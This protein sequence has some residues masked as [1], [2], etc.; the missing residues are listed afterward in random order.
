[1]TDIITKDE[2]KEI[3]EDEDVHQ[4]YYEARE[5]SPWTGDVEDTDKY[6]NRIADKLISKINEKI[7]HRYVNV[8][9][10]TPGDKIFDVVLINTSFDFGTLEKVNDDKYILTIEY[11]RI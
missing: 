5:Y 6:Q 3:L 7:G 8:Y 2:I 4:S 10:S 9:G 1:M 11:K